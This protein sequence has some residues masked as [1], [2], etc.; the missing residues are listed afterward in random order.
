[1]VN[2]LSAHDLIIPKG[3]SLEQVGIRHNYTGTRKNLLIDKNT[4]LICQGFTGKQVRWILLRGLNPSSLI[5][6][7]AQFT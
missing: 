6:C 1:M 2:E 3:L 7:I 4:K 5:C